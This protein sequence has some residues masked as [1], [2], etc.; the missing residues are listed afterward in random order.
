MNHEEKLRNDSSPVIP[1]K[2]THEGRQVPET[3]GGLQ[4]ESPGTTVQDVRDA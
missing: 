3:I 4:G 2:E 1:E